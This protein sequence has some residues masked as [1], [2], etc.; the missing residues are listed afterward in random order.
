MAVLQEMG[1]DLPQD[2]VLSL[3]G[4]YPKVIPPFHKDTCSTIFTTAL[5]II[6]RNWKQPRCPPSTKE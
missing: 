1:I 4:I 6:T 5:F 3:Q 2:L